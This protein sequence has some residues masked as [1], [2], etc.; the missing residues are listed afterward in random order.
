M[1]TTSTYFGG[2]GGGSTA[3]P[4]LSYDILKKATY[5]SV[6]TVSGLNNFMMVPQSDTTFV[7]FEGTTAQALKA[8]HYT[9]GDDGTITED[10]APTSLG[11]NEHPWGGVG[12]DG[13]T[14]LLS[15]NT[16]ADGIWRKVTWNG[17]SFSTSQISIFTSPKRQHGCATVL[18]NGT[19]LGGCAQSGGSDYYAAA[20]YPDGTTKNKGFTSG[21]K[22][23]QQKEVSYSG[24][25]D[26]LYGV[27]RPS[28]AQSSSY[29]YLGMQVYHLGDP[30]T[31]AFTI[32]TTGYEVPVNN[33][34]FSQVSS[35]AVYPT[36]QNGV[37]FSA[38]DGNS[39]YGHGVAAHEGITF[40]FS[41]SPQITPPI[42]SYQ[43]TSAAETRDDYS[44]WRHYNGTVTDGRYQSLFAIKDQGFP[45]GLPSAYS[46][47][48]LYNRDS[49]TITNGKIKTIQVGKYLVA[50]GEV[51][52]T[53]QHVINVY[54]VE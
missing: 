52:G 51:S 22:Y 40:N 46:E 21:L 54:E 37:Y 11:V 1:G 41:Q 13:N 29:Y 5:K 20:I 35:M 36:K 45:A 12:K 17:S 10:L 34:A 49:K 43:Q 44:N 39:R 30:D 26:G 50:A 8:G 18:Y 47:N 15:Q 16:S 23:G 48:G 33:T 53:S 25:A 4:N 42:N 28:G 31:G 24:A 7:T 2:S 19:L 9:I 14:L 3:I 38:M 6:L 27:G 32:G